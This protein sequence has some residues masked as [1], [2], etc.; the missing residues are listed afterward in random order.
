M[1]HVLGMDELRSFNIFQDKAMPIY[2]NDLTLDGL[3]RIFFYAFEEPRFYG[4]PKLD[5]HHIDR[6]SFTVGDLKIQ[7][8]HL[9]HYKMDVIGFRFGDFAYL[10]DVNKIDEDQMH[11]LKGVKTLILD[12][13]GKVKHISHYSLPEAIEVAKQIGAETTYFTHIGHKMGLY[14]ITEKELPTGMHLA[15]DGLKIKV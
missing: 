13:L 2:V 8:I 14:D 10:T 9:W 5:V 7:P 4:L 3:K 6:E 1:D 11:L 15:Y 12:A